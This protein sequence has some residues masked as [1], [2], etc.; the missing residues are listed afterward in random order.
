MNEPYGNIKPG[1]S[2]ELVSEIGPALRA[3]I[4]VHVLVFLPLF[5]VGWIGTW[6]SRSCAPGGTPPRSS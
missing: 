5:A 2:R 4:V 6:R 1:D 3:F